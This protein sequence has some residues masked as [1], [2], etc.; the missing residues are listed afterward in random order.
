MAEQ[1]KDLRCGPMAGKKLAVNTFDPCES[2][3]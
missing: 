2:E 3:M 1:K